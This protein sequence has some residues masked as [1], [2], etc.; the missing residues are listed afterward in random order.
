MASD[1]GTAQPPLTRAPAS[2][3]IVLLG[4]QKNDHTPGRAEQAVLPSVSLEQ[5]MD[6]ATPLRFAQNDFSWI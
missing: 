4:E 5:W 6:S 3:V 1:E 2:T